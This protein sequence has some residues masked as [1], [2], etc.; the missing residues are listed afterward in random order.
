M[1][2]KHAGGVQNFHEK[3]I[4]QDL[5]APSPDISEMSDMAID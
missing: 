5:F 3:L 4:F 2:E 1:E